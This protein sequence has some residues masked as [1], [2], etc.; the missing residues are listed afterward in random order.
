MSS[1]E[2]EMRLIRYKQRFSFPNMPKNVPF[3]VENF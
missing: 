1:P 2:T 3:C